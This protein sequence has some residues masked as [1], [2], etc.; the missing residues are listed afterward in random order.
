MNTD[1]YGRQILDE[2]DLCRLYLKDP[3]AKYGTFLLKEPIK[4]DEDLE[5]E[6]LPKQNK[7][8]PIDCSLEEFDNSAQS[9]W[10][11]PKE[12]Q[13]LDI[14]EWVLD[15][16]SSNEELNR[17]GKE[18]I[19]Y[20]ERDLFPMLQYMKY[21]VDTMRKN[22]IVWGVGRGSSVSSFVL[23]LIGVHKINSLQYGLDVHEFLK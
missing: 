8:E 15:Q 23:F 7:Y 4:F 11:M 1:I 5:L 20:Q 14:A 2:N 10:L 3:N 19:L 6:W 22:K 12:Y 21:L 18:L 17:A 16:C 13:E 9:K